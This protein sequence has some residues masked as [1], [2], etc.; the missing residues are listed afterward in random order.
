M[1]VPPADSEPRPWSSAWSATPAAARW[2]AAQPAPPAN[3][4]GPLAEP[5]DGPRFATGL[6]PPPRGVVP[7]L[8]AEAAY[9]SARAHAPCPSQGGGPTIYLAIADIPEGLNTL[10][11]VLRWDEVSWMPSFPAGS[12]P[13]T[14]LP[15]V[16]TKTTLV[17]AMT[18]E[19]LGQ[20]LTGTS[21]VD[22]AA[23][24]GPPPRGR[25]ENARLAPLWSGQVHLD[26]RFIARVQASLGQLSLDVSLT[27]STT[28]D[29]AILRPRV[30][31]LGTR[32]AE[33]VLAIATVTGSVLGAKEFDEL[34]MQCRDIADA[35]SKVAGSPPTSLADE[36]EICL[37]CAVQG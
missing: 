24:M 36:L 32:F 2:R 4:V 20:R 6:R 26:G 18:G 1:D 16:G 11:Y 5:L 3:F 7:E 12:D 21:R 8:D 27:S 28:P 14:H 22:N 15:A 23:G 31:K 25:S 9:R 33:E 10:V 30:E 19:I 29:I 35:A 34:V 37:R 17:D 13:R